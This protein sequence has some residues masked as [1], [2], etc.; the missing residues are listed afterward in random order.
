MLPF[1]FRVLGATWE[2]RRLVDAGA[3]FLGYATCDPRAQV[4]REAYLSAFAFGADFPPFLEATGSTKGFAGPCWSARLWFDIDREDALDAALSDARR[5]AAFLLERYR[6]LDDTDLLVFFSGGKGF[7][8]CLPTAI[9]RPTPSTAFNSVARSFCQ[10]VA[11][12][13]KV[14]IDDGV[15]D[16]V[17][18]FRAPN[19]RHKSGRHKRR[20]SFDELLNLSLDRILQ[21]AAA[22]EPFTLPIVTATDPQAAADW[23]AAL[24]AVEKQAKVKA[25]RRAAV[26]AGTPTL[27]KQTLDFIREGGAEGDR[28]RLL[29]SAAANLGEFACSP[30]LAHALLT[31]AAL[32]CGL[33][34]REVRRQID[35]GL[36]RVPTPSTPDP[37]AVP[38]PTPSTAAP[39]ADA[40][41]LRAQLAELWATPAEDAAERE[42]IAWEGSQR[43]TPEKVAAALGAVVIDS[44]PPEVP[45]DG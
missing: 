13:A 9:W 36:A 6:T 45:T 44:P 16:R 20:L 25:H 7:H 8:I 10:A 15:F 1:A 21:L 2:R 34:P 38:G 33:P 23:Q 28:H 29:F 3:A 12:A 32:D 37:L 26:T 4:E 41:R 11:T 5:L 35:C 19:S 40:D 42:A 14:S 22:P 39:P 17:R 43:W 18:L 24:R 31:D 30:A 27:N